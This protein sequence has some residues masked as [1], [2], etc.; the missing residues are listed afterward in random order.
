MC[1]CVRGGGRSMVIKTKECQEK[2]R[3]RGRGRGGGR[4]NMWFDLREV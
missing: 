4:W 3:G 2:V 1:V